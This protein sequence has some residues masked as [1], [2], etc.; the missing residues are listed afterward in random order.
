MRGDLAVIVKGLLHF[1]YSK[2]VSVLFYA[3][4]A[5]H[6]AC[7][8]G[9]HL[10]QSRAVKAAVDAG[11]VE[12]VIS[13]MFMNASSVTLNMMCMRVLQVFAQYKYN[14]QNEW[15][16]WTQRQTD[17]AMTCIIA[18]I[19]RFE[20]S[21]DLQCSAIPCLES[22]CGKGALVDD[23]QVQTCRLR[24]ARDGVVELL[25]TAMRLHNDGD[26]YVSIFSLLANTG[27][28]CGTHLSVVATAIQA[29]QNSVVPANNEPIFWLITFITQMGT[30]AP[31][32][33][34]L[35]HGNAIL[36]HSL[37]RSLELVHGRMETESTEQAIK[38]QST[39]MVTTTL[40][41]QL[42]E[43]HRSA[44]VFF[45]NPH[46]IKL[47]VQ[48]LSDSH[49]LS[50]MQSPLLFG[51]VPFIDSNM[52]GMVQMNACRILASVDPGSDMD[53]LIEADAIALLFDVV[54]NTGD[55]HIYIY[56]YVCVYI[57]I[58]IYIYI[59]VCVYI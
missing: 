7:I 3:V 2:H 56:V 36:T 33:W 22:M 31:E 1:K 4:T 45:H 39:N 18:A 35:I 47:I 38:T 50:I 51:G 5:L 53:R 37:T 41:W 49:G 40:L 24:L 20:S 9:N 27:L 8:T 46:S 10:K 21:L 30:D 34:A 12:A 6:V 17:T 26:M 44:C 48:V 13:A 59:Y 29:L 23:A 28:R 43:K 55:D 32:L 42:V 15:G 16:W 11:G 57:Y 25:M 52:C 54:R 19:K 14:T 58:C